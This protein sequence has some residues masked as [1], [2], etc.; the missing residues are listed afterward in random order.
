MDSSTDRLSLA[1]LNGVALIGLVVAWSW[2]SDQVT[3]A[4]QM[5]PLSLGVAALTLSAAGNAL[6]LL[7]QRRR[8]T[9]RL[10]EVMAHREDDGS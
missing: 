9:A 5:S 7:G 6:Y 1:V 2:S 3:L 10:D 4:D 8:L